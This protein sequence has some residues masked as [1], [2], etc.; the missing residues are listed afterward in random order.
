MGNAG[1]QWIP[2]ADLPQRYHNVFFDEAPG[3]WGIVTEPKFAI[4][5]RALLVQAGGRN[6][7]WDCVSVLDRDTAGMVRALGG[8]SAIAISHPHYYASMIEW[9]R[10]FGAP[11][12]LHAADRQWVQRS[13]ERRV[14]KECRL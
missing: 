9:S 11:I 10:E 5:Q 1:Q 3:L 6:I 12:Y 2:F 14:G 8:I 13:E 4:G 7:L